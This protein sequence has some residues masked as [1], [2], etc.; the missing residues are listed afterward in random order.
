MKSCHCADPAAGPGYHFVVIV[1]KKSRDYLIR[2]PAASPF[3]LADHGARASVTGSLVRLCVLPIPHES[4][5]RSER[6]VLR[7]MVSFSEYLVEG[8]SEASRADADARVTVLREVTYRDN[9]RG[10][11]R[12]GADAKRPA[13]AEPI[14]HPTDKGRADGRAAQCGTSDESL[15]DQSARKQSEEQ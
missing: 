12:S 4:C 5:R 6:L 3:R 14:G 2:D 11:I 15:A 9:R 1:G 8:E 13:R 10:K 7:R